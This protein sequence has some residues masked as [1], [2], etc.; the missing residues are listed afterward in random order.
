MSG[1]E[2]LTANMQP[3]VMKQLDKAA[4]PWERTL[5]CWWEPI[6][7]AGRIKSA[8]KASSAARTQPAFHW[9]GGFSTM[10]RSSQR[11]PWCCNSGSDLSFVQT[12]SCGIYG[13]TLAVFS[14]GVCNAQPNE[15]YSTKRWCGI[16]WGKSDQ[17]CQSQAVLCSEISNDF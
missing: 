4:A 7:L 11:R 3:S 6:A 12:E 13:A 10:L 9:P 5:F 14:V 2:T 15:M 16:P 8:L 1:V 17:Y